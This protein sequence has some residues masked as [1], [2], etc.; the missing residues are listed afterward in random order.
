MR[1][2]VKRNGMALSFTLAL[3]V[4]GGS[5]GS[6][7]CLWRNGH[8]RLT[9]RILFPSASPAFVWP[10][11]PGKRRPAIGFN[12]NKGN[13]GT[14]ARRLGCLF[15]ASVIETH[16]ITATPHPY[17]SADHPLYDHPHPAVFDLRPV[18]RLSPPWRPPTIHRRLRPPPSRRSSRHHRMFAAP[19]G[20]G[21]ATLSAELPG[22]CR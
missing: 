15:V 7:P 19:P 2:R 14:S 20:S 17:S 10:T 13:G 16:P 11:G 4:V 22:G 8:S 5:L 3:L 1:Q 21:T 6:C 18:W 9:R 12:S